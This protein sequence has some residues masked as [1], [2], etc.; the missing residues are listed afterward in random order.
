MFVCVRSA[1]A[2][3]SDLDDWGWD[4]PGDVELAGGSSSFDTTPRGLSLKQRS[5]SMEKKF[6]QSPQ[7]F[8]SSPQ[9]K[10]PQKT[11]MQL[12]S[13]QHPSLQPPLQVQPQRITS[14]GTP[15]Q[16]AV[17]KTPARPKPKED[18]IFASMGLAAQPKFQA[19]RS[20]PPSGGAPVSG[21]SWGDDDLDDLFDD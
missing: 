14:F 4:E 13:L 9:H 19:V 15:A 11:G 8:K 7:T 2:D 21:S 6:V 3:D 1:A 20:P 16:S 18:D 5:P 17:K 10:K 12:N